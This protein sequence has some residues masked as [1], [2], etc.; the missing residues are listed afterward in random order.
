MAL[1]SVVIVL[2]P[3]LLFSLLTIITTTTT[4]YALVE[5]PLK[6]NPV[7]FGTSD[8]SSILFGKLQRASS[9][10]GTNLGD[11][12]A[13]LSEGDSLRKLDKLLWSQFCMAYSGAAGTIE[14]ADMLLPLTSWI[15]QGDLKD[16][17]IFI[18]A[19]SSLK[20]FDGKDEFVELLKKTFSNLVELA[21]SKDDDDTPKQRET[22]SNEDFTIIPS[23][24]INEKI[25]KVAVQRQCAHVY[26]LTDEDS[27]SSCLE[28]I[29]KHCGSKEIPCTIV[30]LDAVIHSS[31]DWISSRPQDMEGE[32]TAPIAVS[33]HPYN[34]GGE[35]V[36]EENK[37]I[38]LSSKPPTLPAEDA[39]EVMLQIALRTKRNPSNK[40]RI[41]RLYS[42]NEDLDG[43]SNND[44]FTR[45]GN[46]A[47]GSVYSVSSWE[48]VL[49]P[50]F[51]SVLM[52]VGKRRDAAPL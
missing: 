11:P 24:P 41:V 48:S 9:L 42:G 16:S 50:S 25:L 5:Q 22:K 27:L 15:P 21:V 6:A 13:V 33:K 1:L 32:L 19:A 18:D 29:E 38:H 23:R 36:E 34:D 8:Y 52:D 51:G 43:R 4:T 35:Q 3:S 12:L 28:C 14:E 45:T 44:Y 40:R 2:L 37:R 7:L 20:I 49:G 30:V 10:Y 39:A 31:S 46:E 47:A 17:L 26:I